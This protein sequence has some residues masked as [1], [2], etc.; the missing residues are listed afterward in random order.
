MRGSTTTATSPASDLRGKI[1]RGH[2]PSRRSVFGHLDDGRRVEAVTLANS[3]GVSATIIA[4]G[5]SLQSLLLPGETGTPVDVVLGHGDL[6]GYLGHRSFFGTTVGRVANRIAGASFVID[7]KSY[8]VPANDGRNALHGG[9]RGFDRALWDVA[10]IDAAGM[11]S[12][13]LRH[14]SPAGDQG[15]PGNLGVVARY[16]LDEANILAIDYWATTDRPTVVNLSNHT[17]W[18]LAGEGASRSAMDHILTLAA[19]HFLPVTSDLI[20]TGA[21]ADVGATPF[22]FRNGRPIGTH[23][24]DARDP[25]IVNGRGY[26]HCWITD[27]LDSGH[28]HRMADVTEPV[29]G[30]GFSLWSNQPGLQFYSGNFLDGTLIGKA[31]R[32]YR[33]GDALVLEPQ[34][35]PDCVNQP[36]LGSARLEPGQVYHNRIEY[37][38]ALGGAAQSCDP[39]RDDRP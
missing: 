7:G 25:Q 21:R 4:Y 33:Q 19:D 24:R 1:D 32:F 20:P 39:I 9:A 35:L 8:T 27:P 5:A 23:L 26:D 17:Y 13:E 18:N 30:R 6:A 36:G 16:A 34:R 2:A 14:F 28:L 37:R 11:P 12:V 10:A 22:D 29:S 38:L 3:H 15:F 31:G